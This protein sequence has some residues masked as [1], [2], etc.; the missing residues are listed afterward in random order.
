MGDWL[1]KVLQWADYNR[2]KVVGVALAIGVSSWL[3]GCEVMSD[4]L[5]REGEK[6]TY[7]QYQLEIIKGE[8]D[9]N[10]RVAAYE[11]EGVKLQ[12]E[13][14]AFNKSIEQTDADFAKQYEFRQK[15]IEF[16]GGLVGAA[17]TGNPIDA[18]QAVSTAGS[19]LLMLGGVGAIADK[20]RADVVIKNMKSTSTT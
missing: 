12:A 11:A 5:L 15:A 16:T 10:D 3:I 1:H 17:L 8:K 6:V 9:F 13:I 19:L 14:D 20:R 2:Y 7:N 18:L 4:S